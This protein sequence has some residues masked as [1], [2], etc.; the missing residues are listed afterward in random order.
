MARLRFGLFCIGAL[1]LGCNEAASETGAAR[2]ALPAPKTASALAACGGK[3][4]PDCPLQQWM[5]A[6]LQTYQREQNFD[7]MALAF[8]QLEKNAPE[9]YAEWA[10][11]AVAGMKAARARD[12]ASVRQACKSCHDDHRS[13]YRKEMRSAPW[14]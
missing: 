10:S 1:T 12:E 14:L 3:G 13:R 2:A 5:K 9:G 8:E 6:T 7:R 4:L 11:M